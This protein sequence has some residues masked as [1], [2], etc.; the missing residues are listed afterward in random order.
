MQE[1]RKK[2]IA[3]KIG[4]KIYNL[5]KENKLSREKFAEICDISSQ[6]VYYMEKGEV[7]PGCITILDICNNFSITPSQLLTD[8]LNVDLN[9]F[10]ETIKQEFNKLSMDDKKFLQDLIISTIN[11]LLNKNNRGY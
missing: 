11:L 6:H 8:S 1:D 2:D 5:R 10:D 7:L 3:Q 4:K 9:L